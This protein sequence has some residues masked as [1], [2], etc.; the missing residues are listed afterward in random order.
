MSPAAAPGAPKVAIR[1]DAS[2]A[3]GGGHLGRCLTLAAQLRAWGREVLF[4]CRA[5]PQSLNADVEAA[6]FTLL[7]LPEGG[8]GDAAALAPHAPFEAVVVDHYELGAAW[9]ATLRPMTARIVAIDDLAD[10]AHDCDVLVDVSPPGPG[11]YAGL[12]PDHCVRL[13]GPAFAMLRP[14]F[15][16]LRGASA[17]REGGIGRILIAFGATDPDNRC[18][19][20]ADAA[21]AALGGEVHLDIVIGRHAPHRDALAAR[22][23]SRLTIHVDSDRVAELMAAADLA[24]GAG[25]TMSW[26]RCCLGL[27]AL[28]TEIAANQRDTI[29]ALAAAGCAIPV[30]AGPEFG[31]T[32]EAALQ[33]LAGDPAL[34]RQ[35][36]EAARGLTD[37]RGASRV[38]RAIISPEIRLREARPDDCR[39]LWRWRNDPVVRAASLDGAL[40]AWEGHRAWF[41]ARLADPACAL[42]VA[43]EAGLPVGVLRFDAGAADAAAIS[44]YLTPGNQGRGLGTPLLRAGE[45]WLRA[46]RPAVRRI[47]AEIL[48]ENSASLAAFEGA[49]YVARQSHYERELSDE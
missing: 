46:H 47:V 43:E 20:A 5:H 6:G 36:G 26:E 7:E 38:A 17:P 49:G 37:G 29:A 33:T 8:G 31:S 28:V 1:V 4:V 25:G 45:A 24:I 34:L 19:A 32:V 30:P 21:R 10:R 39:D 13:L 22:A 27:P 42:L 9:E 12:V 23:D 41:A 11:R 35:M 44:V 14:A 2:A 3:I 18:A 16:A 48:P 40:I 15:A